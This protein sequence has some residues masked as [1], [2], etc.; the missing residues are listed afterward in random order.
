MLEVPLNMPASLEMQNL[1]Q[2]EDQDLHQLPKTAFPQHGELAM[3]H[4]AHLQAPFASSKAASEHLEKEQS[5]QSTA[6]AMQSQ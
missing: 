1:C 6:Q 3:S 5:T 2:E 4:G